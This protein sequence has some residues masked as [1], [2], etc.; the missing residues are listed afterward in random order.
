MEGTNNK[1][2]TMNRQ[3]YGLRD[4]EYFTLKLPRPCRASHANSAAW[5]TDWA[6]G[7]SGE[8]QKAGAFTRLN[9]AG[10]FL[11]GNS[12]EQLNGAGRCKPL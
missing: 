2:K 1:I 5:E 8:P 4:G 7:L 12:A 9:L 6:V 3:H 11:S 10:P